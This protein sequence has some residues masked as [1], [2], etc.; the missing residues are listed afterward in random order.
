MV[1][2]RTVLTV[3]QALSMSYATL[4][5]V[6]LGWRVIRVEATPVKG[7]ASMGDPNRFIGR[8]VVHDDLHSYFVGPNVGKE[9]IALDLKSAE[10]REALHRIVKKLDVDVFC[11]NSLPRRHKDFGFDY[12]TLRAV[13]PDIIWASISA[14]GLAHPDVPGYDPVMQAMLGYMDITGYS[15]G[16]PLQNGPPLTDLKAGDEVFAQTMLALLERAETGEGKMIDVSMARSAASWLQTFIPML[17]MGSPPEELK[18]NGN[19]HRQFIPVNAYRT[20]D[21]WIYAAIGSDSQWKRLTESEMFLPLALEKFHTNESRRQNKRELHESIDRETSKYTTANVEAVMAKC[22]VPHARITPIEG[23]TS[24]PFIAQDLTHTTAPDG[25]PVRLP[26]AAVSTAH[27]EESKGEI[28]F[29]P[30]YGEHTRAVLIEAGYSAA[31]IDALLTSEAA[32][33]LE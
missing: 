28:P 2:K 5:F 4:R 29:A 22:V 10:G 6:H 13:K 17:D 14:L 12:E 3:E 15:D 25:S 21:G 8:K 23:V 19:E 24:I 30:R 20:S 16:P 26:P 9:A 11:T 18:R 7:L 32:Y 1:Q 31:E 27:L 33:G